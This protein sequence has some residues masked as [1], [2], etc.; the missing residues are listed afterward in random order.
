MID[1][2]PWIGPAFEVL[3]K[4][5]E[6]GYLGS[7]GGMLKRT[8]DL[9][10][11]GELQIA[12]FGAGGTGKSTL[13][14]LLLHCDPQM[15]NP[16]YRMSF[17][18][19]RQKIPGDVSAR[20]QVVPGQDGYV[21]TEW[22][23][24]FHSIRNARRALIFNVVAFGYHTYGEQGKFNATEAPEKYF[25]E[26]WRNEFEAYAEARRQKEVELL[27]ILSGRLKEIR[28]PVRMV[29]IVTKEDLWW[30]E[31]NRVR[32]FYEGAYLQCLTGIQTSRSQANLSFQHSFATVSQVH[33]NFDMFRLGER[34][35]VKPTA[36]GYDNALHLASVLKLLQ[37]YTQ[38]LKGK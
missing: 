23:K 37:L 34:R 10:V 22:E 2:T 14:E 35:V 32:S 13:A 20:F 16:D 5:K 26:I 6:S 38:L 19:E 17:E 31:I 4:L 15:I 9:L 12:V 1:P 3:R 27:T 8:Y 24:V 7:G 30:S 28:L 36:E 29:T 33:A 25:G 11:N 21:S 18:V